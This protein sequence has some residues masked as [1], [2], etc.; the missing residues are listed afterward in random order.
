MTK[1]TKFTADKL[2]CDHGND[3][4]DCDQCID[5]QIE[6]DELDRA[7]DAENEARGEQIDYCEHGV[8]IE[9]LEDCAPC[10]ALSQA[11]AQR[12]ADKFAAD[13]ADPVK[14]G[15]AMRAN[16]NAIFDTMRRLL[17]ANTKEMRAAILSNLGAV[18]TVA[19]KRVEDGGRRF[20]T[21]P[22][23]PSKF[24]V[25]DDND[26]PPPDQD[27]AP[28][29]HSAKNQVR[30][31]ADL[32]A[33]IASGYLRV[34]RAAVHNDAK[35]VKGKSRRA[36]L[37]RDL[38]A[39]RSIDIPA[40]VQA[41]ADSLGTALDDPLDGPVLW[42]ALQKSAS[43]GKGMDW[44]ELGEMLTDALG[45]K[46]QAAAKPTS[47]A[48]ASPSPAA[49]DEDDGEECDSESSLVAHAKRE[50]AAAGLYKPD[51]AYNGML[52]EAVLEL[53]QT[54]SDQGHSGMSAGLVRSMFNKVANY[55]PLVPLTGAD[56]EWMALDPID[57]ATKWQNKR[58]GRV[59][60]RADGTAYD[61]EGRVFREPNGSTYC[62]SDSRV[63]VMTF[64][65][66]PKT[67]I[68]DVPAGK[69]E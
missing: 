46:A 59:F 62:S 14:L 24:Q 44:A 2:A 17:N 4:A 39:K 41:C 38:L 52:P 20:W 15:A 1:P 5:R 34:R 64:P 19:E 8:D 49:P 12:V 60:K 16:G 53:V 67:E 42:A 28:D 61:V 69:P 55:E 36:E 33:A 47:P 51:G 31:V 56:D 68:V 48:P 32:V 3:P 63:D 25:A 7:I 6:S 50:L 58:C 57:N 27:D 30:A 45:G 21:V 37:T 13:M 10:T 54:F 35:L 18:P 66:T 29:P 26:E 9:K 43:L 65:Y 40:L 22:L 11:N 23:D